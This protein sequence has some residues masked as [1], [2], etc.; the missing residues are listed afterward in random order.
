MKRRNR[1]STSPGRKAGKGINQH[2]PTQCVQLD[3]AFITH[4]I[5]SSSATVYLLGRH[6][7]V[8]SAITMKRRT[9]YLHCSSAYSLSDLV[10]HVVW[11][12]SACDLY[13]DVQLAPTFTHRL[14]YRS[15]CAFEVLNDSVSLY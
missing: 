11:E 14:R 12:A 10:D 1:H 6:E 3:A 2:S 7:D 5:L 9:W 15:A 4:S 8:R 13:L